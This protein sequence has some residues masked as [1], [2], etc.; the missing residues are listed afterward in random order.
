MFLVYVNELGP[1]YKGQNVYEF[2]FSDNLSGIW[3]EDWDKTPAQGSPTP[4]Q[5]GTINKVG[6]LY[7]SN[8]Q[9]ELIQ[10][11]DY[12]GMCDAVDNVIALCWEIYD[13]ENTTDSRLVFS[14]GEDLKSVEDKLYTKDLILNY[15]QNLE[16]KTK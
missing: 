7:G 6:T 8:I 1:N 10:N 3:G 16:Y 11:S 2:I 5:I 14:F 4:P 15:V 9:F 12:F 13:D